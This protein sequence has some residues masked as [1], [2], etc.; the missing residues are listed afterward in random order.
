MARDM[1]SES[2]VEEGGWDLRGRM[3]QSAKGIQFAAMKLVTLL[4]FLTSAATSASA[5]NCV[6]LSGS[7][8]C[9][10]FNA[11]SISTARELTSLL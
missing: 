8:L 7:T 6:P 5:Q 3:S 2:S 9:P 11:S 1:T 10:A 4:A